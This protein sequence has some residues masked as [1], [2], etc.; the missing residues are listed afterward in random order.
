MVTVQQQQQQPL[1]FVAGLPPN[2]S[3]MAWLTCLF[4][5]WPFGIVSIIKSNEVKINLM[6]RM[7]KQKRA[8]FKTLISTFRYVLYLN[9]GIDVRRMYFSLEFYNCN[10]VTKVGVINH[11]IIKIMTLFNLLIW[12]K[13]FSRHW[14]QILPG[15]DVNVSR[16]LNFW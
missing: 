5:C 8:R 9:L 4:C 14:R 15:L 10:W 6:I 11:D 7:K 3:V 16:M 2:H 1:M 12:N 13:N